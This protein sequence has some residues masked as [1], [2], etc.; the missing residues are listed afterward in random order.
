MGRVTERSSENAM[1]RP[2]PSSATAI[3]VDHTTTFSRTAVTGANA[4]AA[5]SSAM[6]AQRRPSTDSGA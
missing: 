3:P 6:M 1:S 4:S 2:R 5:C